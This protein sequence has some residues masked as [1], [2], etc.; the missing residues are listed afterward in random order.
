[1]LVENLQTSLQRQ[2]DLALP[3]QVKQFV[4]HDALL[5]RNLAGSVR[6]DGGQESHDHSMDI[7][8]TV[9]ICQSGDT[10]EFTV[11]LDH[12]VLDIASENSRTDCHGRLHTYEQHIID[13]LCTVVEGVSHAV[14][15]LWHAHHD[16]QLRA[17]DLE[18]QAEVDKYLLLMAC[19]P[20]DDSRNRLHRQLFDN[21]R[22]TAPVHSELYQRY[23]AA[24]DC[25]AS[26][27]EWLT[28]AFPRPADQTGLN[29]E[30]ARFYRLSGS[31]KFEHIRR[32]H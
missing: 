31:A 15:L 10:L 19:N 21:A 17:L 22:F 9:F 26:Y 4:S 25:A 29:Q 12:D 13:S 23:K 28:Q 27:C 30:L 2:Y 7:E 11:Y 1:M 14:C 6:Q 18:L 32:L 3:Y 24:S 20:D 8:E 16:R 5:A